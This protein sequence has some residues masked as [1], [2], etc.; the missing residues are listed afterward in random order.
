MNL[1]YICE[2][3]KYCT[4]PPNLFQQ[5]YWCSWFGKEIRTSIRKCEKYKIKTKTI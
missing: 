3:C 2:T 1:N 4:H 5:Y